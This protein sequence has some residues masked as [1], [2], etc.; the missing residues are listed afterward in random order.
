MFRFCNFTADAKETFE[1]VL[2]S[3]YYTSFTVPHCVHNSAHYN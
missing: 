2:K 3:H 1:L